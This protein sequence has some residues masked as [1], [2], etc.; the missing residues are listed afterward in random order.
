MRGAIGA[1]KCGGK[2]VGK[3]KTGAAMTGR[4]GGAITGRG[5]AT[6]GTSRASNTSMFNRIVR[7]CMAIALPDNSGSFWPAQVHSIR[8]H[9]MQADIS[10]NF[11]PADVANCTV[12]IPSLLLELQCGGSQQNSVLLRCRDMSRNLLRRQRAIVDCGLV[13]LALEAG[14]LV[15]AAAEENLPALFRHR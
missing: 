11:F 12:R 5:G 14:E 8:F 9:R 6:L 2:G 10:R 3:W 15:I 4:G 7:P 1:V 13:E